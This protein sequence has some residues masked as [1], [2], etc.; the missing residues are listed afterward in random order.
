MLHMFLELTQ[1]L[2]SDNFPSIYNKNSKTP[3]LAHLHKWIIISFILQ[4]SANFIPMFLLNDI[5]KIV[6]L[7]FLRYFYVRIKTVAGIKDSMN[8]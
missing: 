7:H 6:A 2:N 3:V 8:M 5:K 1:V 4:S